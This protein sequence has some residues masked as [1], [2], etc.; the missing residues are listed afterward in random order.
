LSWRNNLELQRRLI[1]AVGHIDMPVL[2]LQ[3]AA[4]AS[5]E[6]SRVLGAEFNR[7]QKRYVGKVFPRVGPPA[8]QEHCFG[9]A[10]GTYVWAP[11]ALEFL[12]GVIK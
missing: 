3:P 11:A 12:A 8:V 5:L 1:Q 9:G 6:P 4:D 10:Q 2:L 7:L